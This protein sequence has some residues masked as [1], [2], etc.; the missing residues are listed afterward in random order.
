MRIESYTNPTGT[1]SVSERTV[2]EIEETFSIEN[3]ASGA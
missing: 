3:S 2:K 1:S